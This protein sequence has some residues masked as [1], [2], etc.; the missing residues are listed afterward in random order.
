MDVIQTP[1]ASALA[2]VNAVVAGGAAVTANLNEAAANP[3]R[4]AR[5]MADTL[6]RLDEMGT[7]AQT[8]IN[9]VNTS[10]AEIF[11]ITRSLEANLTT[12][13]AAIQ[14]L[15]NLVAVDDLTG[16]LVVGGSLNTAINS[17]RSSASVLTAFNTAR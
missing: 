2:D 12:T 10:G 7:K 1:S 9:T 5:N 13:A 16:A 4:R 3:A 11:A 17:T 6:K 8:A 14:N 15:T